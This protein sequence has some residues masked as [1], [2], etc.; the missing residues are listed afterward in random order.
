MGVRSLAMTQYCTNGAL[1]DSYPAT[2]QKRPILGCASNPALPLLQ[3]PILLKAENNRLESSYFNT[4]MGHL[5]RIIQMHKVFI[6]NHVDSLKAQRQ[7]K[8]DR[9][10]AEAQIPSDAALKRLD[11]YRSMQEKSMLRRLEIIEKMKL[12]SQPA[13]SET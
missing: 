8:I 4:A 1:I 2:M 9:A 10:K 11:K 5:K 3:H 13:A 7:K 6:Q 12:L